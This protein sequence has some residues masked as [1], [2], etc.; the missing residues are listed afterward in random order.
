MNTHIPPRAVQLLQHAAKAMANRQMQE[1]Q[2]ACQQL[3]KQFPK[4]P[5]GWVS[6][7][8]LLLSLGREASA[9]D[10]IDKALTL[11]PN[12]SHNHLMR[13]KV[14]LRLGKLKDAMLTA[15]RA[16]T[17]GDEDASLQTQV[18]YF[19]SLN[20]RAQNAALP[21]YQRA[22][23]LRPND[24]Q[25]LYNLASVQRFVGDTVAAEAN[26]DR[27]ITL[28]PSD[29]E[30]WLLRSQL[31]AQTFTSNHR[32]ALQEQI[33][34]GSSNWRDEV[35]LCY[36]LA[37]ENEDLKAYPDSFTALKRG[38]DLRRSNTRYDVQQDLDTMDQ[39]AATFTAEYC[40]QHGDS[41]DSHEPI[42][43]IGLPRSGTTLVERI[44][45]SHEDVFAA[46]EL[47]DFALTMVAQA[48][49]QHQGSLTRE[50]LVGASAR[51]NSKELGLGYLENSRPFTG[52]TP[53]FIDKMPLN[54]L[55]CGLIARALPNAKI[56]HLVRQPMDSCYSMYKQMF[57]QA[58]PMSYDLQD[59]G[60]YYL[61]YRKLMAHWHK[62]LPGKILDVHYEH[63]V[64]NQKAESQKILSFCDLTWHESVLE[65][66]KNQSASTTASATQVRQPIYSSSVDKWRN[67]EEELSPLTDLLASSTFSPT[68]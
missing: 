28:N 42:F 17:L 7:A 29:T 20:C 30:A 45:S 34:K 4:L 49:K 25:F 55:Y 1:A 8:Q 67:Y 16:G 52:H 24:P 62:V 22:Q 58:Y 19:F 50:E 2:A 47:N 53:R 61:G 63:V 48:K 32:Q 10:A 68:N 12:S 65:F 60:R 57:S 56:I 51:L 59:L 31:R 38:A 39:L 9:L 13:A 43:I 18:A 21:Y 36:A 46:G 3:N 41:C 35:N 27:A 26:L 37:K 54:F 23:T 40:A 11:A 33:A 66:E 44:L 6:S 14:L 15:A 64:A 5:E